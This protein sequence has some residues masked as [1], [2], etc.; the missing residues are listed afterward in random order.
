MEVKQFLALFFIV[1][2]LS[3]SA[4]PNKFVRFLTMSG[5][6]VT[7]NPVLTLRLQLHQSS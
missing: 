6:S 5:G 4:T 3:V 2:I 7:E 1:F